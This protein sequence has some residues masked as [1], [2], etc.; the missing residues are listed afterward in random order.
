MTDL[1]EVVTTVKDALLTPLQEAVT[2]RARSA[3]FSTFIFSW[4]ILNWDRIAYFIFSNDEIL[5]KISLLKSEHPMPSSRE[6]YFITLTQN[7][8]SPLIL[9]GIVV[10]AYP[11]LIYA[12][13]WIHKSIFGSIDGLTS[14]K[15]R[16]KLLKMN[17]LNRTKVN[18]EALTEKMRAKL[19]QEISSYRLQK[20]RDDAARN[21]LLDEFHEKSNKLQDI[22]NEINTNQIQLDKQESR[23]VEL[24]EKLQILNEKIEPIKRDDERYNALL[25]IN[26]E[27]N[28]KIDSL[29]AQKTNLQDI[30]DDLKNQ[31]SRSI[32]TKNQYKTNFEI[33]ESQFIDAKNKYFNI[34]SVINSSSGGQMIK[35]NYSDFN[36]N[37]DRLSNSFSTKNYQDIEDEQN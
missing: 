14:E 34:A 10:A 15:E 23:S 6:S 30:I 3:F 35:E 16:I 9:A 21:S 31:L 18:G 36:Y 13:T 26:T 2:F 29:E 1:K 24:T 17:K 32:Q 33:L 4:A 5:K 37:L 20:T 11:F 22:I 28:V 27:L 19:E 25:S 12:I 7:I 8:I